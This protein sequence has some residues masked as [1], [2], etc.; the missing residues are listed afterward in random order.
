MSQRR[1]TIEHDTRS[2]GPRTARPP[3]RI[4]EVDA[5]RGVALCGFYGCQLAA[6]ARL[7]GR[8]RLGPVETLLRAV[9]LWRR[10]SGTAS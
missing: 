7:M 1:E 9:T 8:H 3:R 10:S 5:L 2:A 4:V 6:S